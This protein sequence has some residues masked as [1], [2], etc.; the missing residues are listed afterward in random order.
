MS[1]LSAWVLLSLL[2]ECVMM[3]ATFLLSTPPL[4]IAD[5]AG[6]PTILQD[7]FVPSAA[8]NASNP[9]YLEDARGD[10]DDAEEG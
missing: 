8:Q 10:R 3:L 7:A 6:S 2:L 4:R 5:Y 9:T 1:T